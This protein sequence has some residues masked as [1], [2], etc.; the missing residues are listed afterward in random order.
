MGLVW[1]W[2][3]VILL[4]FLE[5]SLEFGVGINI[6]NISSVAPVMEVRFL[7][8][9]NPYV[10]CLHIQSQLPVRTDGKGGGLKKWTSGYNNIYKTQGK[11]LVKCE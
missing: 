7:A 2:G 6:S 5:I 8:P 9:C 3:W 4:E 1:E 11:T 10:I